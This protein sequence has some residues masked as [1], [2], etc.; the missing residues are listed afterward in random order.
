M[1]L[2]HDLA[3]VV[4]I[5][6]GATALMDAWLFALARLGVPSSSF[7]L[8]GRWVG[9]LPRGRFAHTAIAEAA[10][11]PAELPLGWLTHYVIGIAYAGLLLGL[12]GLGWTQQPTLLPALAFGAATVVAP[13]FVMQPAMGAG[14]AASK[15]AAPLKNC[16]RSAVNHAV[17]GT[18]LYVAAAF[19]EWIGR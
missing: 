16:L 10:P 13:L 7:A 14:F 19:I 17:F 4:L 12:V 18:G 8:I 11:I 9:H 1:L 2:A 15:T 3:H 5:G 6:I